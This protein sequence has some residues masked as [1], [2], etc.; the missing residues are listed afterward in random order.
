M[1]NHG[2]KT[3][4]ALLAVI[5]SLGLAGSALASG[6]TYDIPATITVRCFDPYG[7]MLASYGV[8]ITADETIYP[9]GIAGYHCYSS[10][11]VYYYSGG[12]C[13]D[14]VIDF[15][16]EPDGSGYG[17]AVYPYMW[18]TQFKPGTT[19]PDKYNEKRV[20]R[21]GNVSDD[22]Y[23]T[24]FDWLVWG[25]ERKDDI[26]ELTAYFD[27]QTIS[28]IGIRNGYLNSMSEY[29]QYARASILRVTI[30]DC[31][32]QSWET[33]IYIPDEYTTSYRTFPLGATYSDVTRVDIW[34]DSYTRNDEADNNHKN[35]IHIADIQFYN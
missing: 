23:R 18:D 21:L 31:W 6:S 25:S 13:S 30:Y 9:V 17:W 11:T 5:L 14:P 28:S 2:V 7:N 27:R 4:A 12:Y 16:Y 19:D 26:P 20:D 1:R 35:V 22:N 34:L 8:S 32:G 24:S 3:M 33:M 29:Y 15:Y 10:R